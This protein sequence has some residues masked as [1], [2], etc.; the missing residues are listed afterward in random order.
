[1]YPVAKAQRIF[2]AII[3]LLGSA[4]LLAG[5]S[6]PAA[7][8]QTVGMNPVKLSAIDALIEKDIADK[9]L[10][11]A[12]V[13]VDALPKNAAGKIV[14]AELRRALSEGDLRPSP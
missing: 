5:Q 7:Q 9:K 3:L 10:P 1:M 12:V 13:V 8:P 6:L 4:I 14:K 11:G 2:S